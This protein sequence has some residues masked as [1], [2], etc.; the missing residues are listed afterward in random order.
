MGKKDKSSKG[1]SKDKRKEKKSA[2]SSSS[3]KSSEKAWA[4]DPKGG[5]VKI[6]QRPVFHRQ[7]V[8]ERL[9]LCK[10]MKKSITPKE[11]GRPIDTKRFHLMYYHE[12]EGGYCSFILM[13]EDMED[14]SDIR[15]CRFGFKHDEKTNTYSG[16][17][18]HEWPSLTKTDVGPLADTDIK[19]NED[20]DTRNFSDTLGMVYRRIIY[21]MHKASTKFRGKS[22]DVVESAIKNFLYMPKIKEGKNDGLIDTNKKP[23]IYPKLAAFVSTKGDTTGKLIMM[24]KFYTPDDEMINILDHLGNGLRLAPAYHFESVFEGASHSIQIKLWEANKVTVGEKFGGGTLRR[25]MR[26][27]V[28]DNSGL[29][30]PLAKKVNSKEKKSKDKKEKKHRKKHEH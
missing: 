24:T 14:D 3:V 23:S 20:P 11:G 13:Q 16:G 5:I 18:Q 10:P 19:Y 21:L 9:V 22:V 25:M 30:D 7:F 4:I 8:P 2:E 26:P 17:I 1:S 15:E 27:R 6:Q 28:Q 12:E 29:D